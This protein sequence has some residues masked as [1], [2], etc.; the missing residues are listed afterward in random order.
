MADPTEYA[1][2]AA[3]E[4][5]LAILLAGGHPDT[6]GSRTDSRRRHLRAVACGVPAPA[7]EMLDV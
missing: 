4:H 1:G 2:C 3:P 6:R 5:R 7:G